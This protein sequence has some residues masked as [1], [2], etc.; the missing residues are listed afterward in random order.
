MRPAGTYTLE[1]ALVV[2]SIKGQRYCLSMLWSKKKV[3][4]L[5][6]HS[7]RRLYV[8]F[9]AGQGAQIEE[10]VVPKLSGVD[11]SGNVTTGQKDCRRSDLSSAQHRCVA[12]T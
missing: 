3:F 5:A 4:A 9:N 1:I 6:S 11:V 8:R 7:D 2:S 10:Y 12:N